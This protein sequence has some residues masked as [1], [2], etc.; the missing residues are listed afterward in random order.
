MKMALK[1]ARL[2]PEDIRYINAHSTSTPP[3]D[4]SELRALEKIFPEKTPVSSTK[5]A[6]GHLLG[7][8]GSIEAIFS[9]LALRD[10]LLPPTLNLNNPEDTH[11]DLI[12]GASRTAPDI[13]HALSNSFGFGGANASLIFSKL[14]DDFSRGDA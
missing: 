9:I 12:A 3:G 8:A 5:G 6:T 7:A 1:D 10:G 11:L 2:S 4:L 14:K 13:H